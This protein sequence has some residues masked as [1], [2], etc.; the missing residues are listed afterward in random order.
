M[1]DRRGEVDPS[2]WMWD[3]H[4]TREARGKVLYWIIQKAAHNEDAPP[5]ERLAPS[6]R[7]NWACYA[8]EYEA[9]VKEK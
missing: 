1:D 2:A 5:F 9:G 6:E 3:G 7:D 4:M 8:E